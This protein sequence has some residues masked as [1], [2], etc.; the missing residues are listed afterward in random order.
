MSC[1]RRKLCAGLVTER[2]YS[3]PNVKNLTWQSPVTSV[4]NPLGPCRTTNV[5]SANSLTSNLSLIF[6]LILAL[7]IHDARG[8][9]PPIPYHSKPIIQKYTESEHPPA[10]NTSSGLIND[11]TSTLSSPSVDST[12][13]I[14]ST[15]SSPSVDST[16]DIMWTVSCASIYPP[17]LVFSSNLH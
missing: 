15:L 6:F 3:P 16:E 9:P 7:E 17:I 1:K 12:E 5:F 8:P 14:A 4:I 10:Q 2:I 11:A 13:D